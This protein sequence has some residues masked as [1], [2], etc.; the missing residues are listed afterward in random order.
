V[1]RQIAA[2][3]RELGETAPILPTRR[4]SA[5]PA[6][7]FVAAAGCSLHVGYLLN[8]RSRSEPTDASTRTD[9]S[10]LLFS[11]AG[12]PASAGMR[13]AM[14]AFEEASGRFIDAGN[15]VDAN[16]VVDRPSPQP[17]LL[18]ALTEYKQAAVA[19]SATVDAYN[20]QRRDYLDRNVPTKD[21]SRI[22]SMHFESHQRFRRWTSS[23]IRAAEAGLVL[24]QQIEAG[25][26]NEVHR[27]EFIA[28]WNAACDIRDEALAKAATHQERTNRFLRP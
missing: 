4:R 23:A 8:S 28:A 9:A 20:E 14:K 12:H 17:E 5:L 16:G 2:R 25:V 1:Q 19:M 3:R 6:I 13:N 11:K 7:W 21:R 24:R 15:A 10:M 26:P 18:K 22:E 27:Q